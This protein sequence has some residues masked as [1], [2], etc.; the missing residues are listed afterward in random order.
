MRRRRSRRRRRRRRVRAPALAGLQPWQGSTPGRAPALAGLQ[1]WQGSSPD[2]A[3]AMAGLQ[4]WQ[5]SSSG[6]FPSWSAWCFRSHMRSL[7]ISSSLRVLAVA[8]R[9]LVRGP[10]VAEADLDSAEVSRSQ[11]L[12]PAGR[13]EY[14]SHVRKTP[15]V[16]EAARRHTA[17][18]VWAQRCRDHHFRKPLRSTSA[19]WARNASQGSSGGPASNHHLRR[20]GFVPLQRCGV[21]ITLERLHRADAGFGCPPPQVGKAWE[22]PSRGHVEESGGSGWS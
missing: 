11:P 20:R 5:G 14:C 16:K 6:R 1:P 8:Y 4:P 22:S 21:H 17:A 9:L 18:A 15:I 2:R 10:F 7:A 13:L 12:S 19:A 3:P